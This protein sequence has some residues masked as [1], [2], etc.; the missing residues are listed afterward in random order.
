MVIISTFIIGLGHFCVKM[1]ES[2]TLL[3]NKLWDT[4]AK[5]RILWFLL[6]LITSNS[7]SLSRELT[8]FFFFFTTALCSI[9]LTVAKSHGSHRLV[10]GEP[11]LSPAKRRR[12][13]CPK[14]YF[15]HCDYKTYDFVS[16][17]G[18]LLN[19]LFDR[20]KCFAHWLPDFLPPLPAPRGRGGWWWGR[21]EVDEVGGG[22][23]E[24]L[25]CWLLC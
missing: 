22:E 20:M 15:Q 24:K 14:M 12:E 1:W 19:L 8:F 9:S 25:F 11:G 17:H 10:L 23:R 6:F 18:F 2:V 7:R 5:R 21:R 13:S 16:S 3:L 4:F